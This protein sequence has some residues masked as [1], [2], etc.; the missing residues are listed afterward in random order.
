MKIDITPFDLKDVP[1]NPDTVFSF[2]Q[3]LSGFE[4]RTRFSLF[5]EEGKPTVFWLQSLDDPA[6]SF[7]VVPPESIDIEYEIELSDAECA[8]LGLQDPADA[9]VVV[10][11]YREPADGP[12]AGSQIGASTRSPLILNPKTRIGMQKVL[13]EVRP[14]LVYRAR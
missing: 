14:S 12:G 11:V 6:L 3:G 13:S 10:I 2:P 8:L 5:H 1:V 7:S 4:N 9:L